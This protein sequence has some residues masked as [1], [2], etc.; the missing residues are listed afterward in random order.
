MTACQPLTARTDRSVPNFVYLNFKT[1]SGTY[2]PR[3][4]KNNNN[5]DTFLAVVAPSA[6]RTP[7][8]IVQLFDADIVAGV[9]LLSVPAIRTVALERRVTSVHDFVQLDHGTC[10][11][12]ETVLRR[13]QTCRPTAIIVVSSSPPSSSFICPI[14]Q[15][16]AHLHPFNGPLSKTTWVSRYQKG[17]TSLDFTGARDSEWQR[18]Q[19]GHMQVCTLLQTDNHASTPP[20]SFLQAGCPSCR[21][22]N[23]VKALKGYIDTI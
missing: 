3:V 18:H 2:L 14:I 5:V 8:V 12:V 10:A 7:R 21:P 16:Y 4:K 15:Q 6:E 17:K 11:A 1:P 23:S 13:A 19:L 9:A 20:L 22:T